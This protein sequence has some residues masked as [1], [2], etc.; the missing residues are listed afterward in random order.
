MS[1][2]RMAISIGV[3]AGAAVGTKVREMYLAQRERRLAEEQQQAHEEAAFNA[4]VGRIRQ[5]GKSY[6]NELF[7]EYMSIVIHNDPSMRN[8]S[9]QQIQHVYQRS[10]EDGMER[11][12]G[13]FV[14]TLAYVRRKNPQVYQQ[15]CETL[16]QRY[17][18]LRG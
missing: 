1:W 10:L 15:M 16:P 4:F 18:A 13:E 7:S 17:P 2:Q 3:R 5:W 8:L 14:S 6:P 9:E 11:I 12:L